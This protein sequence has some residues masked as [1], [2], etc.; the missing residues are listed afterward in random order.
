MPNDELRTA[1][2]VIKTT[3][4]DETILDALK[5]SYGKEFKI[6]KKIPRN[7]FEKIFEKE[8]NAVTN[9]TPTLSSEQVKENVTESPNAVRTV[10]RPDFDTVEKNSKLFSDIK[11]DVSLDKIEA[12]KELNNGDTFSIISDNFDKAIGVN[13]KKDIGNAVWKSGIEY[14]PFDKAVK[15]TTNY[16]LKGQSYS[17]KLYLDEKNYGVN[18][19]GRHQLDKNSTLK[20]SGSVFKS[21]SAIKIEYQTEDKQGNKTALGLY[22]STQYKEIGVTFRMTTF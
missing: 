15:L 13:Y 10:M 19:G 8:E 9:T 21:D 14:E 22:G 17:A 20:F 4:S 7:L 1:Y 11:Y 5:I 12:K 3:N 2:Q 18:I 16:K 6:I